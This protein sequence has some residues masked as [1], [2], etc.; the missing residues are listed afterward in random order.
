MVVVVVFVVELAPDWVDF[1]PPLVARVGFFVVV[2]VVAPCAI[3]AP[4]ASVAAAAAAAAAARGVL[5]G[6]LSLAE[7]AANSCS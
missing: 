4:G 2:V 5:L 6:E 7:S 1:L 3:I